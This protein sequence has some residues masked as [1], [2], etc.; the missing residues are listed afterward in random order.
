MTSK[1]PSGAAGCPHSLAEV[2]LFAP[3][4]QEYWYEAYDIL[5][6]EAPVHRLPGEGMSPDSDAFILSCHE[7]VSMVVK[8]EARFPPLTSLMLRQLADSGADPASHKGLNA[9]MRSMITLRP[10]PPLW[11]SHRQELTDPWVGPGAPRN[12]PMIREVAQQLVDTWEGDT[13]DFVSEFAQPLPHTVMARVLGWPL[14][15]LAL[16]KTFGDGTVKPFVYGSTHR[17]ILERDEVA[18][19]MAVLGEFEQYTA[20][21]IAEKR[22]NPAD[23]MISFLTEVEYSPLARRLSDAE[24]NGIVYAMVIGGLETTQYALAEQVQ[25]LIEHPDTWA[26]IKADHSRIRAFTEEAMRLRAPTQGLSTR[27]TSRDE[28]FQGVKVPA[29]SILH[30]RWAAANID[31]REW[32]NPDDLVLDRKAVTR[33]LTFSQGPRVCPGATLSRIE[34]QVAWETLCQHVASFEYADDNDFLHQP[35]IMLGTLRLNLKVK[36]E[37]T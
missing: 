7:D 10:N 16:L 12:E 29:G 5:H 1:T 32:D 35:G 23:D 26:L 34:Q 37:G 13:V 31:P 9:M 3:G 28:E 20:D 25:L 8:D 21:L 6:Q 30:L 22:I 11:R 15:D 17:C 19:Q 27:M 24:I 33:H 4:A 36:R 18:S 14:E 2:D